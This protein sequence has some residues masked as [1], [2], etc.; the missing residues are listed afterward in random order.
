MDVFRG[1][2]IGKINTA[3]SSNISRR[4]GEQSGNCD[5][6]PT[7]IRIENGRC[8]SKKEDIDSR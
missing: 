2:Q 5:I 4:L 8:P 1:G 6:V 3:L 7:L